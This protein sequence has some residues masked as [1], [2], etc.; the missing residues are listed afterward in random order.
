MLGVLLALF[1]SARDLAHD[2]EGSRDL[3]WAPRQRI[4]R[5]L[6]HDTEHRTGRRCNNYND[7]QRLRHRHIV[8][9]LIAHG[10]RKRTSSRSPC[11]CVILAGIMLITQGW[12]HG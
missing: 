6:V 10:W 8:S 5:R 2:G 11:I 3:V 4:D 7:Y 9:I 12:R 1:C